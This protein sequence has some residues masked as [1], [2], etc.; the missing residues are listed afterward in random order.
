MSQPVLDFWFD[1]GSTYS[2]P[3]IMRIGRLA[4][5]A[6]VSIRFRPFLRPRRERQLARGSVSC[7]EVWIVDAVRSFATMTSGGSHA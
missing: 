6:D 2:Y 3:A 7:R 5:A 1:F 4:A